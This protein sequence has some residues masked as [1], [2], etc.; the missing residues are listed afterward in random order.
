[1]GK[2]HIKNPAHNQYIILTV[3]YVKTEKHHA[4]VALSE[5]RFHQEGFTLSEIKPQQQVP[6][7]LRIML[8]D[9]SPL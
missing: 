6:M 2:I 8:V 1:M 3:K 5:Q 7:K 9:M 4:H